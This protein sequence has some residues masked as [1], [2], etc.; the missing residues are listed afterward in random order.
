MKATLRVLLTLAAVVFL[1]ASAWATPVTFT[2]NFGVSSVSITNY[3][4]GVPFI[5]GKMTGNLVLSATP[6]TLADN[7]MQTLDFFTLRASGLTFYDKY[8]VAATLAFL[9]PDIAGHATGGGIFGTIGG[10]ISA[11]TLFWDAGTLPDFFT[12][13]D[14]NVV[15][16]NFQD[17]IAIAYGNSTTT[18]DAYVTNQGGAAVPEPSTLMLLGSGLLGLVMV[19]RKKIRK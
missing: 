8:R 10:V 14:G 19:G 3:S 7:G 9:T 2:P 1:A 6:F 16:I 15:K 4:D 17:G 12:L 13:S 5:E 18:V 11:G